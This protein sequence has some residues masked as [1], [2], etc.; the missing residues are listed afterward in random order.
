MAARR[1][2]NPNLTKVIITMTSQLKDFY[3]DYSMEIGASFSG[4]VVMVLKMYMD[5]L[6]ST[7][8][9]LELIQ[10]INKLQNKE[11]VDDKESLKNDD[12]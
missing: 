10:M 3:T 6:N 2:P 4:V 7:N 1:K 9:N 5:G 12:E 8:K 11:I